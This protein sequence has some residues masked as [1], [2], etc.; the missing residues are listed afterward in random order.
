MTIL[1][2][3]TRAEES[4]IDAHLT[5]AKMNGNS[6]TIENPFG[7]SVFGS[8]LLRV[9]PDSATIRA[10]I[11][12]FEENPS[13]A[14]AKAREGAQTVTEF[15]SRAKVRESGLSRISVSQEYRF[16]NNEK[17]P[18]G[19]RAKIG[20]TVILNQLDQ[21]EKTISGLVE[22][23]ANEIT[24]MEFHTTKLKELRAQA[25]QLATDAA[26][27]KAKTYAAAGKVNLGQILHIQDVNPRVLDQMWHSQVGRGPVLHEVVDSEPDQH[28]LDPS[29]IEVGAAVLVAY[30][31]A[32]AVVPT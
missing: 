4:V 14:F 27:E 32:G 24:S 26:R 30:R 17:R 21:I 11:T 8:A 18:V 13:E 5:G 22:A 7:I 6:L 15:L 12:R 3:L 9:S 2:Q 10:A 31:I 25:R 19:Y 1:R 16:S 28:T 20:I 23:G 29:A